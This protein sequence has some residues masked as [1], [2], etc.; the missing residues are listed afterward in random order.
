VLGGAPATIH[1]EAAISGAASV[2]ALI[3]RGLHDA[4]DYSYE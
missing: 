1:A 3:A 4:P 2:R